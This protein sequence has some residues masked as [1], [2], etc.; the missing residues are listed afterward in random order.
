MSRRD[1]PRSTDFKVG[2]M[3]QQFQQS[4]ATVRRALPAVQPQVRTRTPLRRHAGVARGSASV[5][6]L[7]LALGLALGLAAAPTAQA[8][9]IIQ[10]AATVPVAWAV[11]PVAVAALA[12]RAASAAVV[13]AA[14][15]V[16]GRPHRADRHRPAP[17]GMTGAAAPAVP[18]ASRDYRTILRPAVAV[19]VAAAAY[20]PAHTAA[21]AASAARAAA[22]IS[23]P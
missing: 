17:Q 19:A 7:T 16:L 2:A 5:A 23:L 4:R 20:R 22:A 11:S 3:Q 13:R 15:A 18:A 8:Q 6:A 1:C 9:Q 14:P 21:T 12:A 10:G